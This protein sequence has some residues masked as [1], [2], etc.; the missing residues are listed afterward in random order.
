MRSGG[1][2]DGA[3]EFERSRRSRGTDS[4]DSVVVHQERTDRLVGVEVDAAVEDGLRKPTRDALAEGGD[5]VTSPLCHHIG[6]PAVAGCNATPFE[7][8]FVGDS[9]GPARSV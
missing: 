9:D 2:D 5:V 6:I 1:E 8:L 4:N 3:G 7:H